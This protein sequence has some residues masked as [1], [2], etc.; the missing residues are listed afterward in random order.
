[1]GDLRLGRSLAQSQPALWPVTGANDARF[2]GEYNCLHAVAEV[3]L[4][5]YSRDV[6]FGRS[7]L[8]TPTLPS[9][10]KLSLCQPPMKPTCASHSR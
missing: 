1:M 5:E 7:G 9:N 6:C 4:E 3:Q 2:V 8:A 10:T